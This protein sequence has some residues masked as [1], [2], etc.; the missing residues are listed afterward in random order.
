MPLAVRAAVLDEPGTPL[1]LEELALAEPKEGEVLIRIQAAGVC[2]TDLHYLAGDLTCAT[3]IVPGHEGAGVVEQVGPGVTRVRPGDHVVLMWRP[4]CG[5]C[6]YCSTGRPALCESARVQIVTNGLLD[7]TTRL[8]RG[9]E[10]VHHLL[11]VSCFAERCVVAEQSVIPIPADIPP[12]IAALVG[13]AV[14]TGIGSVL[15]VVTGAAGSSILVVGAGGVGLSSV[16]GARFVGAGRIIVADVVPERLELAT[17]LGA[18]HTIDASEADLVDAVHDICADG[19][20]W[21]LEAVG[22]AQTIEQSFAALRKGGAVV[23]VGLGKVDATFEVPINQLVQ[24]EKRL[25][26]SLYGSANTV[27]DVPKL[28]ELYRAGR[29]PLDELVGPAYPLT[30]VNDAC[31][32]LLDGAVGRVVLEVGRG[33]DEDATATRAPQ[34]E[35][36]PA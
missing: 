3:P 27:T 19:V 8:R 6:A 33:L 5:N 24:Q 23:A 29:L 36:S 18:T 17:R 1:R 2:H 14:V 13:C 7:G 35:P 10:D 12:R 25:I 28:L 20:D 34:P 21:A 32:A 16:I 9:E 22:R 30:H 15:N 4:R 31:Q 26:G 11:G